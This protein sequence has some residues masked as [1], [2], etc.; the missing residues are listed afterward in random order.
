MYDSTLLRLI[1]ERCDPD[2]IIDIL[3]LTSEEIC[4]VYMSEILKNKEEFLN[5]LDFEEFGDE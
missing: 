5:F 3:G 4:L 2:T 1:A